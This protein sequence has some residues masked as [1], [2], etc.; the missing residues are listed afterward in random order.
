MV[1]F[2]PSSCCDVIAKETTADEQP[3]L[4]SSKRVGRVFSEAGIEVS[5]AICMDPSCQTRVS[6]SRPVCRAL[7]WRDPEGGLKDM[8]ARVG[9]G[10]S[11]TPQLVA[12]KG[13]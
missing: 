2:E 12:D 5:Q 11:S 13:G 1:S 8:S 6:S 10:L 4:R 9:L 7:C 3:A